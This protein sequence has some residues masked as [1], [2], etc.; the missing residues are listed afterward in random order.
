VAV[1]Q[2]A[3]DRDRGDPSRGSHSLASFAIVAFTLTVTLSPREYPVHHTQDRAGGLHRAS[4]KTNRVHDLR[5]GYAG[6][7]IEN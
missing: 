2:E 4:E 5:R 7:M 1:D 3:H 6:R